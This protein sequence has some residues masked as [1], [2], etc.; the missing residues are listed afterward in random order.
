MRRR[1]GGLGTLWASGVQTFA[2]RPYPLSQC[3]C[4]LWVWL[5]QLEMGP[6]LTMHQSTLKTHIA[7]GDNERHTNSDVHTAAVGVVWLGPTDCPVL[8]CSR[9][10]PVDCS[11]TKR[12]RHGSA[13]D[14]GQVGYQ[15][16]YP[17]PVPAPP[18][19]T[20]EKRVIVPAGQ[21]PGFTPDL[22]PSSLPPVEAAGTH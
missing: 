10:S 3:Y 14:S 13:A 18:I 4:G 7:I 9:E 6:G 20:E 22:Y 11:V 16:S 1:C 8:R 21:Q 15:T 5:R 12:S 19:T 2:L 17:D